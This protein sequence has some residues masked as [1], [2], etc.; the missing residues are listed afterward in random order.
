MG[1]LLQYKYK[2]GDRLRYEQTV[3]TLWQ[4]PAGARTGGR[5]LVEVVMDVKGGFDDGSWMV[6]VTT[7]PL[8]AEGMYTIDPAEE[9]PTASLLM[10][11]SPNGAMTSPEA[12]AAMPPS[13]SFPAAPVEVGATW[14]WQGAA[15]QPPT[16][17]KLD[18][19]V[20][21]NG[22]SIA[23]IRSASGYALKAEA[24]DQPVQV[25]IETLTM[26]ALQWG[27]LLEAR[28]GTDTL[29]HNGVISRGETLMRLV[30]KQEADGATADVSA[31]T[32]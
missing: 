25:T 11:M 12:G 8:K 13:P 22:Q 27:L 32:T 6:E 9:N 1:H 24:D 16:T 15:D 29:Y 21:R 20:E 23:A 26:F 2:I 19:V 31:A 10:R 30:E 7:R 18:E 5:L 14:A 3:T 17:F 28:T 4:D